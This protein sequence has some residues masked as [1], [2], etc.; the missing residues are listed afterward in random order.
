[1]PFIRRL[2]R[3]RIVFDGPAFYLAGYDDHDSAPRARTSIV[4]HGWRDDIVSLLNSVKFAPQ[5]C[6]ELHLI[7][8]DRRL[9]EAL[10]TIVQQFDL[11]LQNHLATGDAQL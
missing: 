7:D 1:M 2:G 5:H 10:P 6:Y 8:G 9:N 3:G 11:F 4:V